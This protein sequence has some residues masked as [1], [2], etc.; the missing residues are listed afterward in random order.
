MKNSPS[1]ELAKILNE[2]KISKQ[3][4]DALLKFIHKYKHNIDELPTNSKALEKERGKIPIDMVHCFLFIFV[5]LFYIF[6]LHL[7]IFLVH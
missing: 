5:Y 4:E 7:F 6:V 2:Y 3:C 1:F